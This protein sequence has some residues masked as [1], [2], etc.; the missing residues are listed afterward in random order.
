MGG[1]HPARL[2]SICQGTVVWYR[3]VLC[4]FLY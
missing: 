3:I 4:W 1:L 2:I